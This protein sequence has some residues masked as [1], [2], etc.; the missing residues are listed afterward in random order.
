MKN[1]IALIRYDSKEENYEITLITV[2]KIKEK[3]LKGRYR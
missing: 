3:I 1:D 2:G